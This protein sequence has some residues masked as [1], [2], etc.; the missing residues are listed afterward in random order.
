MNQEIV[1]HSFYR[2]KIINNHYRVERRDSD[3]V[4]KR[5]PQDIDRFEDEGGPGSEDARHQ[6]RD[7]PPVVPQGII[8]PELPLPVACPRCDGKDIRMQPAEGAHMAADRN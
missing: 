4:T 8:Q 5:T 7:N 6:S 1:L 3:E 2:R